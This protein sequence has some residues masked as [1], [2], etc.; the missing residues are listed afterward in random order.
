MGVSEIKGYL[1]LGALIIRIPLFRVL[2]YYIGGPLF[3][4]TPI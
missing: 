2:Y 3:S 1:I 4:E